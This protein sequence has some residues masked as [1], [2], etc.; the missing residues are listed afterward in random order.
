[1][2]SRERR[3]ARLK[4]LEETPLASAQGLDDIVDEVVEEVAVVKPKKKKK[5]TKKTTKKS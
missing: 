3:A 1:M 5:T 2:G 4:A